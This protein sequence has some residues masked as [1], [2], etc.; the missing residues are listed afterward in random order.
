MLMAAFKYGKLEPQI[1]LVPFF[2]QMSSCCRLQ[3]KG[4]TTRGLT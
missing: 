4:I 3:G 2:Q 1:I